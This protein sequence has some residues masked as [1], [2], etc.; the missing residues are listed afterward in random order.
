MVMRK[1]VK[2]K[3]KCP[4]SPKLKCPHRKGQESGQTIHD[5]RQGNQTDRGPDPA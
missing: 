2:P 1:F 3:L 4:L 5:E